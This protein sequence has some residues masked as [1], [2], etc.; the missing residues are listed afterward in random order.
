MKTYKVLERVKECVVVVEIVVFL[1]LF[2]PEESNTIVEF[3]Q[4]V[5]SSIP[6][7]AALH[8]NQAAA[9]LLR[10]NSLYRSDTS[11][12][13][14]LPLENLANLA[15]SFPSLPCSALARSTARLIQA[16]AGGD[17]SRAAH[18]TA[19]GQSVTICMVM[20]GRGGIMKFPACRLEGYPLVC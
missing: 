14:P 5:L 2:L 17:R 18:A 16:S 6:A 7:I 3:T 13:F 4:N 12:N 1:G 10:Q 9:V 11:E 20:C 8:R 15:S 19:T